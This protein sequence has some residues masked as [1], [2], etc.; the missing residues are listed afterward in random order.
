MEPKFA[1][2]CGF[3]IYSGYK[4]DCLDFIFKQD[5][6]HIVSGNPEVLYTALYNENL[7]TNFKSNHS[8]IIPD[9]IGVKVAASLTKQNIIE[10]IAGIELMDS[11]I[12]RCEKECKSIY[13]LGASYSVIDGCYRKLKIKYPNLLITGCHSGY[14]DEKEKEIILKTIK[15]TTPY[16]I[17]VALG[18]PK[19]EEFIIQNIDSL[20]AHI[21]MG[22]G[23]SFDVISGEKKRAPKIMVS[24]G[25]EWLYRV[26]KE[27]FRITR[28]FVIPKF[29]FKSVLKK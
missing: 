16:A 1:N 9:G 15:D 17:F 21:F 2:I 11:I 24:L 3:D 4:K 25:L 22:V 6:V 12:A 23:G 14:F 26:I 5:K 20:P 19:Q 10:K 7:N 27:P 8:L 18:C 29:L 28:L 13:L